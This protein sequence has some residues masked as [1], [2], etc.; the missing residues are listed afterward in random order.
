MIHFWTK[1]KVVDVLCLI[2][3]N[4]KLRIYSL[5]VVELQDLLNY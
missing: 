1:E 4:Y 3:R 2:D 5:K